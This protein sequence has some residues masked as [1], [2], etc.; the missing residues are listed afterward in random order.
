MKKKKKFVSKKNLD[1]KI[2]GDILEQIIMFDIKKLL[3]EDYDVLKIKFIIGNADVGE[4][5]ILICDK[6]KLHCWIFEIKH[7]KNPHENQYKHFRMLIF[8]IQ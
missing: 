3:K 8:K 1:E 2:K 7:T 4:F 5:D 6:E